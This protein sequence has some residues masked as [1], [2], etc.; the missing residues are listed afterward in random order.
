[1]FSTEKMKWLPVLYQ[2]VENKSTTSLKYKEFIRGEYAT[3]QEYNSLPGEHVKLD[4]RYTEPLIIQKHRLQREREE[5][6]RSRGQNFYL[7]M[8]QRDSE[9]YKSTKVE[10]LFD[11]DE[12]GDIQR[13]VILQGHS[14]TG[15]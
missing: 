6:I 14:G 15:K 4:D 12:H 3:V 11:P 9:T 13:T 8:D 2:C 7:L 5:E 1:M 10:R